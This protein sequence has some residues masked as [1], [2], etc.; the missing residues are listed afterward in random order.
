MKQ[1]AMKQHSFDAL[2]A[3]GEL[4]FNWDGYDA[5]PVNP[6][7]QNNAQQALG[8]APVAPDDITANPNGTISFE[9]ETDVGRAHL[10]IGLSKFSFYQK[11]SDGGTITGDGDAAAI[12]QGIVSSVSLLYDNSEELCDASR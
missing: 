5:L 2:A 9:W 7:T 8:I 10:E 11:F 6:V 4:G 12:P 1:D 3:I